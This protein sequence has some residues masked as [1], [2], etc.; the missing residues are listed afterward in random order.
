[1]VQLQLTGSL[2]RYG[3][4][5]QQHVS[6]DADQPSGQVP[7]RV[8]RHRVL[9]QLLAELHLQFREIARGVGRRGGLQVRRPW[10]GFLDAGLESE[11]AEDHVQQ[12][13]SRR[14]GEG[15]SLQQ[16]RTALK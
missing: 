10:G 4:H 14:A 8:D 16:V 2:L 15:I 6:L 9:L 3:Q 11:E 7:G 12:Q 5:V 13:T 1:M